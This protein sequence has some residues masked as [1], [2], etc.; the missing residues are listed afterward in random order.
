[1]AV[2]HVLIGRRQR[3]FTPITSDRNQTLLL[4]LGTEKF[5]GVPNLITRVG[6]MGRLIRS[7]MRTQK[8]PSKELLAEIPE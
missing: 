5:R 2:S 4:T 1:V 7:Q 8:Q 3:S 6:K